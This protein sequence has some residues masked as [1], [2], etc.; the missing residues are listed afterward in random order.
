MFL[1]VT[2]HLLDCY[3]CTVLIFFILYAVN[4]LH[5]PSQTVNLFHY[6]NRCCTYLLEYNIFAY[7]YCNFFL[8]S[9]YVSWP[10]STCFLA[11]YFLLLCLLLFTKHQGKICFVHSCSLLTL[12]KRTRFLEILKLLEYQNCQYVVC[13]VPYVHNSQIQVNKTLCENDFATSYALRWPAFLHTC[14]YT[15]SCCTRSWQ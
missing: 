14:S 13:S 12:S 9:I 1:S 7:F 10:C 8:S 15:G 5:I 3:L 11:S 6:N 4:I 2:I